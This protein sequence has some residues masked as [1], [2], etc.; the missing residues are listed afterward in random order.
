MVKSCVR[1]Y[2]WPPSVIEEMYLDD[3]DYKGI[4]FWYNDLVDIRNQIKAKKDKK[5]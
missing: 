4:E 1:E 3:I 2:H 5:K